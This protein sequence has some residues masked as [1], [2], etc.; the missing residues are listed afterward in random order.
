[1]AEV[2]RGERCLCEGERAT[3]REWKQTIHENVSSGEELILHELSTVPVVLLIEPFSEVDEEV[4]RSS[5]FWMHA[6]AR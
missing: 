2:C 6:I 5:G 1:M 4:T 3:K